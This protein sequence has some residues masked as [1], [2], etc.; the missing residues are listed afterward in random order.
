L[1]R[2]RIMGSFV[3]VHGRRW[4][5]VLDAAALRR[6][7]RT[8]GVDPAKLAGDRL[9]TFADL[10]GDPA[11]LVDVLY[12][13]CRPQAERRGMTDEDF[14]RALAAER[15]TLD[16]ARALAFAVAELVPDARAR[17]ALRAGLARL[18]A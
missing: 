6:L 10:I 2:E 3:D 4:S 17:A 18:K 5:V 14:G 1:Y 8:L 12:V 9:G 15:P 11:R 13:V 7:Q 16:A